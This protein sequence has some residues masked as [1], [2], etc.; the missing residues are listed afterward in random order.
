M[1]DSEPAQEALIELSEWI[2]A[3]NA[4]RDTEAIAWGRLAKV[5][6]EF[7]EVIA[8][9][10]GYTGQ[11]PRKGRTHRKDDVI[12]EL[13]DVAVAALGAVEHLDRHRGQ[14]IEILFDKIMRVRDRALSQQMTECRHE[15]SLHGRCTSCGLTWEEQA[16]VR[17]QERQ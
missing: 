8:A 15:D 17:S 11:N 5:G 2:D 3:G 6:E 13:L 12:E 4:H 10:I 7:G 9:W 1:P 14:S 16:E